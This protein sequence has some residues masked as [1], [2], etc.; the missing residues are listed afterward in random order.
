MMNIASFARLNNLNS[1]QRKDCILINEV[2]RY[3]FLYDRNEMNHKRSK[4]RQAAWEEIGRKLGMEGIDCMNRWKVIRDRY[5]K[6][7]RDKIRGPKSA[8]IKRW[9]YY[10]LCTFLD[11]HLEDVKPFAQELDE[12]MNEESISA[13]EESSQDYQHMKEERDSSAEE[14]QTSFKVSS[15]SSTNISSATDSAATFSV[16]GLHGSSSSSTALMPPSTFIRIVMPTDQPQATITKP[17]GPKSRTHTP[18][19][20]SPRKYVKILPKTDQPSPRKSSRNGRVLD[21]DDSIDLSLYKD[22]K[23]LDTIDHLMNFMGNTLKQLPF[24]RQNKICQ[25]L[26]AVFFNI[27]TNEEEE[28]DDS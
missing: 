24:R 10:D 21:D 17:S 14:L 23:E 9:L 15:P 2:K 5:R 4:Y 19:K 3:S 13:E 22:K 25:E 28:E 27:I 12:V 16:A 1:K 18:A 26:T 7:K 6:E 20:S 8:R 11:P